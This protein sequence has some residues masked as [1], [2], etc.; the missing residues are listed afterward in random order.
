MGFIFKLKKKKDRVIA[1]FDIGSDSI[2][3]A[4]AIIP[5]N[6]DEMP[7]ILKSIRNTIKYKHDT[8]FKSTMREALSALKLTARDLSTKNTGR[9]D[10]IVCSLTSPWSSSETKKI[11]LSNPKSFVFSQKIAD[12][13][14]AKE[15]SSILKEYE[16]RENNDGYKEHIIEKI[17]TDVFLDDKIT[18]KPVGKKCKFLDLNMTISVAPQIFLNETTE[19]L[20]KEFHSTPISFYSFAIMSYLMIR[21]SYVGLESHLLLDISGEV[22]DLSVINNGVFKSK[23]SFP[24]GKKTI[25]RHLSLKLRIEIRDAEE[26]FRLYYQKNLSTELRNKLIPTFN[27]IEKFWSEEL[28]LCLSN[29]PKKYTLPEVIF[30]TIDSDMRNWFF[31][32]FKKEEF[33]QN[34]TLNNKFK[35]VMLDESELISMCSFKEG[36]HD[37]FLM[38]EASAL[39]KKNKNA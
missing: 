4:I 22:T 28:R 6:P 7:T 23:V 1:I 5:E 36:V 2:G 29:I 34:I 16:G 11:S 26:L 31:E 18:H 14:I 32:I 37:P 38:I 33:S 25:M 13:L 39:T 17:V 15:S 20:N 24:F 30:L 8:N 27:A 35:V 10:E 9:L 3:G 12:D 19:I 21:E